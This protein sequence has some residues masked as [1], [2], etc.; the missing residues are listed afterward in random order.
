[1]SEK[2]EFGDFQTPAPL[3]RE[4]IELLAQQPPRY[5]AIVEPTCG[6]GSILCAAAQRFGRTP[7]Y[8][9]FDVNAS[10]VEATK[11]ALDT[12]EAHAATIEHRDFYLVDWKGFFESLPQPFLVV[13][14]PPWITN[15]G[16]SAIKGCNIPLKSNAAGLAGLDAVTGKANFD[17]SEWMLIRLLEAMEGRD[18]TLAMLVKSVV[19]RKVVRHAWAARLRVMD[20][21]IFRIDAMAHFHAAVDASLLIVR[22]GPAIG[23]A[24]ANIYAQLSSTIPPTSTL[25]FECGELVPDIAAVQATLHLRGTGPVKWRSGIKHDCAKVMELRHEGAFLLNGLGEQV[26]VE[27]DYLF[28]MLKTSDVANGSPE[29]PTRFMLVPQRFLGE[30][31]EPIKTAAPRT[32]EYLES[33]HDAFE[34]RGSSIYRGKPRFSVF[35]VGDYTFAPWKIAISGMYKT[36]RFTKVGPRDG[37]PVVFDDV[38]NFL[39]CPSEE[40]ADL[41]LELLTTQAAT[42]FFQG[43]VFWDSKRPVTVDLLNRLNLKALALETGR[44]VPFS[45][46]FP[47]PPPSRHRLHRQVKGKQTRALFQ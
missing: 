21:Q 38:T 3:A 34:R 17:I 14:N 20:A 9:G 43:R 42:D 10:Y 35:G 33:H 27:P 13:G 7:A 45:R 40:A 23:A 30:D 6:R 37:K 5:R 36:L 11:T 19:A 18:A 31:T 32:W 29:R 47:A 8:W 12:L 44:A 2:K 25:G 46:Q 1:M 22:C 4:V 28:P 41:V 39:P 15:A 24:R 26:R 16:M